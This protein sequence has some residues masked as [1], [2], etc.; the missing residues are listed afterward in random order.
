MAGPPL[1]AL[2]LKKRP[3][4]RNSAGCR[5]R[6]GEEAALILLAV[7][8]GLLAVAACEF[9]R[10]R[11]QRQFPKARRR[12]GNLVVWLL[13][14]V[15]ASLTFASPDVFRPQFEAAFGVALPSWPM[16]DRWS[17][18]VA[19]FLLLDCLHYV[20][21][22]YQH[23][24]RWLWRFHALHHSDLDVDVTT[25]VRHHPIEYMSA[26]GFY[27]L[28]V[29]ALG[30][31]VVV[32]MSH[33]FAVFAAAAVTHGNIRLPAW[34]ERALQP[35]VITL[36]LHLI[37]HSIVWEQAN[38]NFGAVLSIWDRLFG[39]FKPTSRGQVDH[40]VFGVRELP[41]SVCLNLS[42]MLRVPWRLGGD[43]AT[44]AAPTP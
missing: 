30:V 10:P 2:C 36:D 20:V 25:S 14:F 6:T 23:S 39:T 15:L 24:V 44:S 13:N 9:W 41:Q 43:A 40:L 42:G 18:L 19:A 34:L 17:S 4:P 32:V 7:I 1:L 35:I 26:A 33:A 28:A 11:R 29:L 12:L 38:S 21:H 31:P 27:W 22:R 16:A 8:V 5:G 3:K 37:H